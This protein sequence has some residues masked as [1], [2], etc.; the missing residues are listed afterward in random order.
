MYSNFNSHLAALLII[1]ISTILPGC[2]SNNLDAQHGIKK[3]NELYL[4]SSYDQAITQYQTVATQL[5]YSPHLLY[6]I[7]NSYYKKGEISKAISYYRLAL[8]FLPRSQ[9]IKTNLSIARNSLPNSNNNLSNI[10]NSKLL[11]F[12]AQLSKGEQVW[13]ALGLYT[14]T[15]LSLLVLVLTKNKTAIVPTAVIFM[16]T[17]TWGAGVFFQ[18]PGQ[19]EGLALAFSSFERS[20]KPAIIVK[21]KATVHSGNGEQ[22]QVISEITEGTELLAGDQREDWVELILPGKRRGWVKQQSLTVVEER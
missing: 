8:S 20:L 4:A 15:C 6:N 9:K 14:L 11:Y 10:D 5:G 13:I 1:T 7:G 22:Y 3:A 18:R 16:I 21:D 12:H 2:N 17:V 19:Y